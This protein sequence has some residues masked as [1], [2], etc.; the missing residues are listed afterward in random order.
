MDLSEKILKLRKVNN[1]SQEQ[2]AEQLD[3]SIV[4]FVGVELKEYYTFM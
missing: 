1:L 3:V 4:L 2:L